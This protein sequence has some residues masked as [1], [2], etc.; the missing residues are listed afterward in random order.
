MTQI[1]FLLIAAQYCYGAVGSDTAVFP[2]GGVIFL[3]L[4]IPAITS[5]QLP[6][7]ALCLGS[8]FY[9][10]FRYRHIFAFGKQMSE[11]IR[12]QEHVFITFF[13]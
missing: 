9:S 3:I 4:L 13:H 5:G 8:L 2:S 6:I 10:L 1:N 7:H 12:K 11:L